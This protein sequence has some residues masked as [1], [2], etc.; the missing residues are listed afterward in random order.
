MATLKFS[1]TKTYGHEIGLSCAF[2]QHAA[3]SHCRFIHGYAIAVR[4]EFSADELDQN[5]WVL[6]FGRMARLKERLQALLDHKTLVAE[7]D[8]EMAWF[9]EA[10][11][12]GIVQLVKVRGA[13]CER[14][15]EIIWGIAEDW[16]LEAGHAPRVRL[17]LVEV[18]EHGANSAVVRREE[19]A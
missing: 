6:D 14:M 19:R 4:F 5:Y 10:D 16:L 11:R 17:D 8:P 12:R 1:S 2:R 9:E 18:R 3:A 7:D 13:G 15:A